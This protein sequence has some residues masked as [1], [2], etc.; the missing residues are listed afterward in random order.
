MRWFSIVRLRLRSLFRRAQVER[1][2]DEELQLQPGLTAHAL[3]RSKEECR[4]MRHTNIV[5]DFVK[6]LGLAVRI[7]R[8][9]P[10]F[11]CA[12]IATIALGIGAATAMFSITSAVLL[13]PLP[14]RDAERLVLAGSPVFH[15]QFVDFR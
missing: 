15:A 14:Y 10:V 3:A 6:D 7:L 12:A 5:D 2:L 4:D 9:S 1:E 13:R 8:K 11:A